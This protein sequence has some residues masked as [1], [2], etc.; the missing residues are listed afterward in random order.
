MKILHTESSNGFGG[1]EIRILK[2]AEGM[3]R[4]G[5]EII[6]AVAK[7]GGLVARARAKGFTVYEIEFKKHAALITLLRL[8][9]IIS[10]HKIDIVNTHSSMDAWLGGIAGKL[11][12][13]KVV[14]TRH[15]STSIRKG[16]NSRLLYNILSDRIVTTS[17][18]II[19]MIVEQSKISPAR[20][21]CIPTGVDPEE[22]KIDQEKV[23]KFREGLGLGED[24]FLAG[25]ACFVRSWKG[26][27][28]LMKT[29]DLLRDI[30]N[31][32][33]II[34]GG[35]YV[36]DYKGIADELNLKGILYFTG[37]LDIPFD[38]IAAMDIFLLLSTAHEGISQASLQ[39]AYLKKPLI[40]TPIGGLPE[41]CI[42]GTTG[43]LVPPSSPHEAAKAV[44]KLLQNADL[45]KQCGENGRALVE[46]KFTMQHTL[47]CMT[48]IY[49]SF[50]V[51]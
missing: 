15:L 34:V 5:H 42:D 10:K 19:P 21:S 13:K 20:C 27:P 3:R 18:S 16:L 43:L 14:R 25:T 8:L 33:W 35:G 44:R 2:E 36:E 51:N 26:I 28:D 50:Y 45:R 22:I 39:A 31:L 48:E 46:S 6:M 17:S 41:V 23:K 12:R 37:H 1:Q 7:G 47:D 40:T 29:A 30:K 24:D 38:A 9:R 4:N 11:A 49:N 32:K